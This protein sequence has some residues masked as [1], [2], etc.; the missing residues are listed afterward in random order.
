MPFKMNQ[1]THNAASSV[2]HLWSPD[3]Y[4]FTEKY[5][6]NLEMRC[7]SD[8]QYNMAEKWS[9]IE[10]V[11]WL[12]QNSFGSEWKEAFLIGNI[13]GKRFLKLRNYF[14]AQKIAPRGN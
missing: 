14:E 12:D 4:K 10:T 5:S 3:K 8:S 11:N 6:K 2:T 13:T 9:I 1:A 7:S